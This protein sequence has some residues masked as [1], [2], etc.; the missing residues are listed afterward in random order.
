MNPTL[1]LRN[2]YPD[3]SAAL[4]TAGGP[5]FTGFVDGSFAAYDDGSLEQLWEVNVGA[6]FNA[7][8]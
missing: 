1:S 5:L 7:P 6:G 2:P 3:G 4:T 8:L